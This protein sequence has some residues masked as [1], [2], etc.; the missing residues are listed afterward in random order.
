MIQ[1]AHLLVSASRAALSISGS[2]LI[3][4]LLKM[5][6]RSTFLPKSSFLSRLVGSFSSMSLR[7]SMFTVAEYEYLCI[8]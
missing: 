3:S 5:R 4:A 7:I 2:D 1:T 8:N 6:S